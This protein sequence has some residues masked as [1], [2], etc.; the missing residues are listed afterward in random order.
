MCNAVPMEGTE[1]SE[2]EGRWETRRGRLRIVALSDSGER[3]AVEPTRSVWGGVDVAGKDGLDR[4]QTARRL[5]R[6]GG[7][8]RRFHKE[9]RIEQGSCSSDGTGG[10][11]G[12]DDCLH[13]SKE[14][15]VLPIERLQLP[16]RDIEKDF[17]SGSSGRSLREVRRN[18][19]GWFESTAVAGLDTLLL[20]LTTG[21]D[22]ERPRKRA[23]RPDPMPLGGGTF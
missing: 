7:C 22:T 3:R 17:R 1:G 19:E 11:G 9:R 14:K 23:S 2:A 18:R 4:R 12:G 6:S 16:D 8:A 15:R 20:R 21:P 5:L 13:R 10:T